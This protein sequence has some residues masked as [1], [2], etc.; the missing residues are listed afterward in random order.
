MLAAQLSMIAQAGPTGVGPAAGAAA[1]ARAQQQQQQGQRGAGGAL[2]ATGGGRDAPGMQASI[3]AGGG[4]D[5]NGGWLADADSLLPRAGFG[6]GAGAAAA[7][8]GFGG[9]GGGFARPPSGRAAGS[10]PGGT[11]RYDEEDERYESDFEPETEA[12]QLAPAAGGGGQRGEG[13]EGQ[14]ISPRPGKLQP[15]PTHVYNSVGGRRDSSDSPG[16]GAAERKVCVHAKGFA[17]GTG[18]ALPRRHSNATA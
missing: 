4:A 17:G 15:L 1:G 9:G 5:G 13:G 2:N 3:R 12:Q 6:F 8:G 18:P 7:A 14:G 10:Q 11:G 16:G